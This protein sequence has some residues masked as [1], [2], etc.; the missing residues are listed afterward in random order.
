MFKYI[1][2]RI[3]HLSYHIGCIND[4]T[5]VF[6]TLG[7]H[8]D[9][10]KLSYPG[11]TITKDIA[12]KYWEQNKEKIQSY[13][14]IITSD[15]VAL[16][17]IFL[18]QLE[19][20]VPHLIIL[21]CNRFDYNMYNEHDFYELLR[22]VHK[23]IN[24]VTYIPYTI[25]EQIWCAKH[26]VYTYE[27]TITPI[28]KW[29]SN[30]T[31]T[32]KGII[33]DFGIINRSKQTL[34]DDQ[35][36]FIQ[37]YYNHVKFM[38]LSSMLA[39]NGISIAYGGYNYFHEIT[40]YK[41][42]V[43]LPD[44]FSKYFTF[45]SI[46]NQLL[47]YLPSQRFLLELV[48]QNNYFFNIAGSGGQLQQEWINLCEWYHWPETRI[49]FDSFDDLVRKINETTLEVKAEKIRWM[50]YYGSVIEKR[51]LQKWQTICDKISM[52]HIM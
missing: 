3:L 14:I 50:K 22:K 39:N 10:E 52:K 37:T 51:E 16:S 46:Q 19:E 45:E 36:I 44:A 23:K 7:H 6:T 29:L 24:K 5:Y 33:D 30:S 8:I 41:A 4:L 18:L 12:N 43:I 48:H 49:Y 21:N 27:N 34:L 26:G 47:I 17:Y 13:D 38:D 40:E 32:H 2:M 20:L 28:G 1:I 25:F 31:F 42:L 11:C 35:T 9:F 15:T